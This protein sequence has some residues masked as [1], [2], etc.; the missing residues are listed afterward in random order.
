MTIRD[1]I[2]RAKHEEFVT[3]MEL[4]AL[5]RRS[6]QA[7]W[8]A[9]RAGRVPGVHRIGRSI[10]LHRATAIGSFCRHGDVGVP[11]E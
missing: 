11:A 1:L 4:A 5:T 7:V 8:R 3:V 2:E 10:R 9:I 6:P